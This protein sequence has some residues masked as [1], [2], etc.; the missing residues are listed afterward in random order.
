M[1]NRKALPA[2]ISNIIF[3]KKTILRSLPSPHSSEG[4]PSIL[5]GSYIIPGLENANNKGNSL[6]L[7]YSC[8]LHFYSCQEFRITN[9]T[10]QTIWYLQ[11]QNYTGQQR[12]C[13][14]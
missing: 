6:S 14:M 11:N 2:I 7:A 13:S 9:S 10:I 12:F 4:K 1:S 3:K 8:P 5:S